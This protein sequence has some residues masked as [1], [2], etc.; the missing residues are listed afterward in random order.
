M[1]NL[2]FMHTL[3]MKMPF[4]MDNCISNWVLSMKV[5]L[6]MDKSWKM[7]GLSIILPVFVDNLIRFF[8][9]SA[10]CLYICSPVHSNGSAW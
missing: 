7:K 5:P 9:D 4:F 3:S 8:V 2:H 1:E 10:K 6:F